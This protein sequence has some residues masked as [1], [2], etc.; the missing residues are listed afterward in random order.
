VAVA[1]QLG[2]I[3]LYMLGSLGTA[4]LRCRCDRGLR[5]DF[6]SLNFTGATASQLRED[7][8]RATNVCVYHVACYS[9][10]LLC[11]T[12]HCILYVKLLL[13]YQYG[14]ANVSIV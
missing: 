11:I 7:C 3:Y 5:L 4:I 6:K 12:F 2:S 8:D 13:R 9:R 14:K 10:A 1:G